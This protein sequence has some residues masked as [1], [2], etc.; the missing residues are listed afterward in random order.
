[1]TVGPDRRNRAGAIHEGVVLR[2]RSIVIHAMDLTGWLGEILGVLGLAVLAKAEEQVSGL[3]EDKARSVVD[4][5]GRVELRR[6]LEDDLLI[7]PTVVLVDLPAD[8]RRHAR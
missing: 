2:H 4:V 7:G 6:R 3:V 1:M 8:D 5:R